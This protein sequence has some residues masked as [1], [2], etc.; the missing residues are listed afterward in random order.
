MKSVLINFILKERKIS[1]LKYITFT[2]Y[3]IYIIAKQYI[4]NAKNLEM[5][6][7]FQI[8]M[9]YIHLENPKKKKVCTEL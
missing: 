8:K 2:K 7:R 4:Y 9:G 5:I 6:V 1:K 3:S